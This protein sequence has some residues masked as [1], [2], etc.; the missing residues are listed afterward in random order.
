MTDTMTT[1]IDFPTIDY[2]GGCRRCGRHDGYLNDGPEH[3][4]ICRRHRVKWRVG[5]NL[6]SGWRDESDLDRARQR[7]ELAQFREAEPL[8]VAR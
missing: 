5:S 6:F 4:F 7:F 8:H 3:W 2:W 1:I